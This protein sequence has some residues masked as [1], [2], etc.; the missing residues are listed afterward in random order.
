VSHDRYCHRRGDEHRLGG[1]INSQFC[2][3]ITHDCNYSSYF[4]NNQN[5]R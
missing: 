3:E 4:A 1:E 5:R 2:V